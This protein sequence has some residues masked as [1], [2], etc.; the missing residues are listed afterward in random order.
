MN[1]GNITTDYPLTN[2]QRNKLGCLLDVLIP[3]SQD[4]HMP[5][6]GDLDLIAYLQAKAMDFLPSLIALLDGLDEDFTT[7]NFDE[8]YQAVKI[9]SNDEPGL[10]Q[11]LIY[12]AYAVYYQS[13]AV[14]EGIGA[15]AG[16][17][18]PRGN[19]IESGDLSLLDAVLAT[20]KQYRK[21]PS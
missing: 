7:V 21:A 14:L 6:A 19:T 18:F 20:P 9:L 4:G 15:A 17:P 16:A 11:A 12:Q 2:A 3:A 8:R 13:P 5:S 10:F 1:K